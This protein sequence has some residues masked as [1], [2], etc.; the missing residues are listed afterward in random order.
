MD[1]FGLSEEYVKSET[2]V[3][4]ILRG[5]NDAVKSASGGEIPKDLSQ[6]DVLVRM[7]NVHYEALGAHP[8]FDPL[9]VLTHWTSFRRHN[10]QF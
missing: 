2:A 9:S 6:W 4:Q 5:K 3:L 8:T 7:E 10:C 1:T